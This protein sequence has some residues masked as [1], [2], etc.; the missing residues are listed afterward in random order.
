MRQIKVCN[1]INETLSECVVT[2]NQTKKVFSL[3]IF[4][5][6]LLIIGF[7]D[8]SIQ[9]RNQTSFDKLQILIEHSS[10]LSSIIILNNQ[11]LASASYDFKIII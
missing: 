10:I 4:E 5:S 1:K 8:G 11:N 9:I 3:A 6:T 7:D 2:L